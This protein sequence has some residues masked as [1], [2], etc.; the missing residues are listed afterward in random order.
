M[1]S[2][3]DGQDKPD[4][5]ALSADTLRDKL[6]PFE[7]Y[8]TDELADTFDTDRGIIRELLDQLSQEKK[9]K[10]KK[11]KSSPIIWVKEP[12]VNRCEECDREFEI[13]FLHPVLSSVKFCP[14]CGT[15]L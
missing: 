1:A 11:P 12:P 9:V 6:E 4:S 13:K 14:R 2:G 7:P 3:K 15:Q 5:K 10:K 8:T